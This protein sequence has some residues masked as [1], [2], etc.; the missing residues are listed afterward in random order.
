[1]DPEDPYLTPASNPAGELE[2]KKEP[3][4]TAGYGTRLANL[5]IDTLFIMLLV[6]AAVW[7]LSPG[8]PRLVALGV[9]FAYYF[10]LEGLSGRTIGKFITGTKVVNIEG[11]PLG[12]SQL[13]TRTLMRL[14]PFE[15]LSFFGN[16]PEGWHDTFSRSLVIKSR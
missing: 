15:P 2:A 13:F 11:D 6:I 4:V 14:L 3:L 5:L 7:L 9:Y 1:M 16:E 10:V 8:S 12:F